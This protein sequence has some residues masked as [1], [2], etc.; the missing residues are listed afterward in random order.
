MPFRPYS[1]SG[2]SLGA[3]LPERHEVPIAH[4]L[5]IEERRLFVTRVRDEVRTPGSYGTPTL[6][7]RE[8]D[9]FVGIS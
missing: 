9:V 2:R 6:T 3:R 7:S 8:I 5:E 1:P 4:A